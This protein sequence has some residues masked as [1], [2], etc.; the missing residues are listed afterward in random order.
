MRV[1]SHQGKGKRR[2][3][4]NEGLKKKKLKMSERRKTREI[5]GKESKINTARQK[6]GNMVRKIDAKKYR[7][8]EN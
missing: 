4:G 2:E 7:M 1:Y 8:K 6:I 5:K 3:R